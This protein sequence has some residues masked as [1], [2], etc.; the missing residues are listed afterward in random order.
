VAA[1]CEGAAKG[2]LEARILGI[3]EPGPIGAI[4]S[5]VNHVLD[6]TDAFVR[7][8][9]GSMRAVGNGLSP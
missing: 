1:V 2:D 7:E 3:P 8:A 5:T 4:M 6:I 9:R